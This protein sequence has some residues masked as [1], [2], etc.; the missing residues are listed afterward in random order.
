MAAN[1]R[2]VGGGHYAG[3]I[4][5]WDFVVAQDLNYFEGQIVKYV[6]RC[7]KKNGVEDLKKAQHFLEKYLEVYDKYGDPR[8][9][10]RLEGTEDGD[11][12]ARR[13]REALQPVRTP[14]GRAAQL[15]ASPAP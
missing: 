7:R 5:H 8:P 15:P 9:Q 10:M 1:E 4:Q 6:S 14:G 11:I 3:N 12:V 2:Q 13:I